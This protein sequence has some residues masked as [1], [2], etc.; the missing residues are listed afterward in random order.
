MGTHPPIIPHHTFINNSRTILSTHSPI[1]THHV[2]TSHQTPS[3][4]RYPPLC[5]CLLEDTQNTQILR[6]LTYSTY[7][8]NLYTPKSRPRN[9]E[10][11]QPPH[12]QWYPQK[13]NQPSFLLISNRY[14][15][16]NQQ[17]F[18]LYNIVDVVPTKTKR[19]SSCRS[20]HLNIN[21]LSRVTGQIDGHH[22]PTYILRFFLI[23]AWIKCKTPFIAQTKKV[24]SAYSP[25]YFTF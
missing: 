21:G 2:R 15:L 14:Q 1:R 16:H 8:T 17:S 3:T 11:I 18:H 6:S 23:S 10:S 9:H 4:N 12:P 5:R 7:S 25:R 20:W 19:Q 13:P 24:V 22:F